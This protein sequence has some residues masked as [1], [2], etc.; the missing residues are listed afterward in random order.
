MLIERMG[1]GQLVAIYIK[2]S[3]VRREMNER[4][5]VDMVPIVTKN[6]FAKPAWRLN[7]P[8]LHPV[9]TTPLSLEE[10]EQ[11]RLA[12]KDDQ[13][14]DFRSKPDSFLRF[15]K[16]YKLV[17][18]KAVNPKLY[19]IRNDNVMFE[20]ELKIIRQM[21]P[22]L[23][24]GEINFGVTLKEF[25]WMTEMELA[26]NGIQVPHTLV[27]I[28]K[29]TDKDHLVQEALRLRQKGQL[30]KTTEL[31]FVNKLREYLATK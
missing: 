14:Y 20:D 6:I 13:P 24:K 25:F 2:G 5:D 4:S 3:F 21:V 23:E 17:Y 15:I 9:V 11:N 28:A 12:T 10:F 1:D 8:E 19:P 18:G 22:L 29:G 31:V 27:G 7:I 26:V 30:D 16:D